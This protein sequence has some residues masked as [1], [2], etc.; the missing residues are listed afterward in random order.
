MNFCC[1]FSALLSSERDQVRL[2]TSKKPIIDLELRSSQRETGQA[3]MR[4]E[5]GGL[6]AS[7]FDIRSPTSFNRRISGI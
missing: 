6:F 5:N 4:T 7:K 3:R 2:N 1:H